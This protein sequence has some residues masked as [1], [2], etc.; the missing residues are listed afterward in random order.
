MGGTDDKN[1]IVSLT[2][3]EHYL[4][5]Q[6][7]VKIYPSNRKLIHAVGLMSVSGKNLERSENKQYGWIKRKLIEAKTGVKRSDE[8]KEK[9]RQSR[10]NVIYTDEWRENNRKGQL[11]RA[12]PNKG[13]KFTDEHKEKISNSHKGK[14][15]SEETK[16][17]IRNARALQVTSDETR[18]KMSASHQRR[19]HGEI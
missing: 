3:E 12:S 18:A 4:V 15:L 5:H 16:Q 14:V 9:M 13:K 2:A 19:L 1:N 7:L 11:G 8:T 6:L 10:K 17:K